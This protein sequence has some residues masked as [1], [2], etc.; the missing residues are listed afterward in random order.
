MMKLAYRNQVFRDKLHRE[1]IN[2]Y[3]VPTFD[4]LSYKIKGYLRVSVKDTPSVYSVHFESASNCPGLS[5]ETK[6]SRD[7]YLNI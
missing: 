2:K 3:R 5:N 7:K 1:I 6:I 4:E